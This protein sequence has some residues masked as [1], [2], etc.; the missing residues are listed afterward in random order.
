MEIGIIGLPCSGKSTL[1]E[2]MTGFHSRNLHGETCIRSQAAVP[3]GRFECLVDIFKPRKISPAQIPFIDCHISGDKSLE[4]LRQAMSRADA[5]LHVVDAFSALGPSEIRARYQKEVEKLL[6]SDL[7]VVEKRMEKLDH[8]MK[9]SFQAIDAQQLAT[10]PLIKAHLEAGFP[11]RSYSLTSDEQTALKGFSFWT[12]R[13]ELVVINT[14]EGD[15]G[16]TYGL[17]DVTDGTPVLT[18]CG[19]IEAEIAAMPFEERLAYLT[20][21]NIEEPAV[22]RVIRSAFNLTGRITYF[23]VGE[24]EVKAWVIPE[25]STAPRAAA[26]IH[27]DFERGFIRAEV[28]SYNDFMSYGKTYAGVKAAGKIRLEGKDYIVQDGDIINFRFNV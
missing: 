18:V 11:L 21:M 3:D 5:H 13:P 20:A 12:I 1:F 4:G 19:E 15:D 27:Q 7:M 28:I 6:L 26:A 14:G 2:A 24:D 9:K 17:D 8:Q 25:G 16:M 10:L 22:H 23:T